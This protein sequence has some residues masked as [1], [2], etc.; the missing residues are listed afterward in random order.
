MCLALQNHLMIILRVIL[1]ISLEC[2]NNKVHNA[3]CKKVASLLK[4][5]DV[6][7]LRT[8]KSWSTVSLL[9]KFRPKSHQRIIILFFNI[10]RISGEEKS[11]PGKKSFW[12]KIKFRSEIPFQQIFI[13]PVT[14]NLSL[15]DDDRWVAL[16]TSVSCFVLWHKNK[17][18]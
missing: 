16:S 1:K 3:K 17:P 13:P 7:V 12:I 4:W 6:T 9:L 11:L 14:Q 2:V 15:N 5:V 18:L 8:G 10:F